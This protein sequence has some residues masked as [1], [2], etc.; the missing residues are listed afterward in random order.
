MHKSDLK[1]YCQYFHK[2]LSFES[3]LSR[4]HEIRPNL[5]K[6]K[7]SNQNS[8]YHHCN[9]DKF[10]KKKKIDKLS[11]AN[12]KLVDYEDVKNLIFDF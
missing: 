5:F 12:C 7:A 8:K 10:E 9:S 11:T 2:G 6:S 4:S 1:K 3:G